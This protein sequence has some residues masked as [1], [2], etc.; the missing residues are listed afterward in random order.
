MRQCHSDR[1]IILNI[2]SSRDK[3]KNCRLLLDSRIYHKI[4]A[5]IM[6]FRAPKSRNM[7]NLW[8]KVV[9]FRHLIYLIFKAE[10]VKFQK[11]INMFKIKEFSCKLCFFIDSQKHTLT[12]LISV[13][14]VEQYCIH[15]CFLGIHF[16]RF[17]TSERDLWKSNP[18]ETEDPRQGRLRNLSDIEDS[19]VSRE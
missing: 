18:N 3:S 5:T 2:R 10:M 17:F 11:I 8:I 9:L 1:T 7:I 19:F 13:S 4:A 12:S 6:N 15:H 16:H 14:I